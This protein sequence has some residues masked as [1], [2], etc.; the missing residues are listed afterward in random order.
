MFYTLGLGGSL[1]SR[2][3]KF[4]H[5]L[6]GG[7]GFGPKIKKL[8]Q[9]SQKNFVPRPG[10]RRQ[11]IQHIKSCKKNIVFTLVLGGNPSIGGFSLGHTIFGHM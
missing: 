1:P 7:G 8:F 3:S 11:K 5:I 9:L 2:G 4:G 6:D 10:G